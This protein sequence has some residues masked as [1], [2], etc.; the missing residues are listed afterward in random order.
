[1]KF[2]LDFSIEFHDNFFLSI[3]GLETVSR[4][5]LW[6]WFAFYCVYQC[7][8]TASQETVGPRLL[9][10]SH[11]SQI[12][13][14]PDTTQSLFPAPLAPPHQ[15]SNKCVDWSWGPGL[16]RRD[17]RWLPGER[18][19]QIILHQNLRFKKIGLASKQELVCPLV[20]LYM[21]GYCSTFTEK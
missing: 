2:W 17:Q 14:T 8:C 11:G 19:N 6:V 13:L 18:R 20:R 4:G 9:D 3:L 10:N 7:T 15:G 1:M 5:G 16:W 21:F 12:S